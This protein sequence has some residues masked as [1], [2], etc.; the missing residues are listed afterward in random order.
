MDRF[1]PLFFNIS[2]VE[3]EY[4]DPQERLFLECV[5]GAMEDAGYTRASLAVSAA[6]PHSSGAAPVGVY[7]GVMCEE[8]QLFG[9][10]E[11]AKGRLIALSG[12]SG[13]IANR[14]SYFCNFEGPS[15]AV[16]TMCS[17]SMTAIHLAC[18][19]LLLGECKLAIA[20][21]V[22]V[23]IHP[24]KFVGLAR[25]KFLSTTGRCQAFGQGADGYVPGEGVGAVLLKP[26]ARAIADGD[27]IYGVI[28]GSAVNHGA[29]S[30]GYTV[31]NPTAQAN[32]IGRALAQA[33]IAPRA[34]GY[35]EAHGTGTSLGDPIEI[36]ALTRAI[37]AYTGDLHFCAIGSV[38]SNIGHCEGAAGIA[39]VT[40][41]LLQLKH[42]QLAPTLHTE[43]LNPNID[44][45]HSPFVVQQKLAAWQRSCIEVD[46]DVREYP[47]SAGVSSFGAGGSNA[48]LI[49]E[50]YIPE[51]RPPLYTRAGVGATTS[52][53][54]IVLSAKDEE[55]LRE[56]AQQLLA[57]VT[58]APAGELNLADVAYTLQVGREAMPQRLA[59]SA[60]SIEE[61]TQK[62]SAYLR[63]DRVDGLFLG[64][65][66]DRHVG[67]VPQRH[68]DMGDAFPGVDEATVDA[69]LA[70]GAFAELLA[71][72]VQGVAFDW[73]RLYGK[74]QALPQRLSLPTYPF[75][76]QRYW[77]PVADD[78]AASGGATSLVIDARHTNGDLAGLSSDG[79][80]LVP[81]LHP[82]LHRNTSTLAAVRFSTTFTGRETFLA[83][84]VVQ[85]RRVLPA[86]T[87][88]EMARA[89][90]TLAMGAVEEKHTL[91][92][93]RLR[94]VI[95]T[96]PIGLGA[97]ETGPI[98][99]HLGLS[100]ADD[101][102][103][104]YA[105]YQ[106]SGTDGSVVHSQGSVVACRFAQTLYLDLPALRAQ[107]S[108]A[109]LNAEQCYQAF[110]AIGIDY[111]P[112]HRAIETLYVGSSQVLAKLALPDSMVD[113]RLVLHPSLLDGALQ[114]TIGLSHNPDGTAS[115]G[116]TLPF[117]LDELEVHGACTATMWAFIRDPADGETGGGMRKLDIDICDETGAVHVR[118]KGFSFRVLP[119]LLPLPPAQRRSEGPQTPVDAP[120]PAPLSAGEAK[121]CSHALMLEPH[122]QERDI[123]EDAVAP[124]YTQHLAILCDLGVER[125]AAENG[126]D[127]EPT[128][129]VGTRTDGMRY[130]YLDATDEGIEQRFHTYAVRVFEEIR[131]ILEG[132]PRGK[133]LV[134]L[135]VP[136]QG[137]GRLC[138][139]LAGLLKTASLEN[140]NLISQVIEVD[141][142]TAGLRK[143]LQANARCPM[144]Q[145]ICYRDGKRLVASWREVETDLAPGRERRIPWRD[146][147]VYLITGGAGG[148]GL[149]FAEEIVQRVRDVT[150][151]LAG[152]SEPDE[153][154]RVL[155]EMLTAM[156]SL[157]THVEYRRLDVGQSDAV[158][159]LVRDM[160]DT[161][162]GLHGVLHSAGVTRDNFILE[163]DPQ[164]LAAV[165]APKVAGCVH[166]DR[167]CQDLD[168][169]VLFSSLTGVAGNPGQ[170][171]Y[172]AANAFMDAFAHY[173]N[174]LVCDN[175]RRGRTLSID[176]PLWREGGMRV[177]PGME[178]LMEDRT[179]L[180]PMATATGLA[181]FYQGLAL[182]ADQ[183]M[184]L[185]GDTVQLRRSLGLA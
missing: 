147:G 7:V 173:R 56:R 86:V 77:V 111:G 4:M 82:L 112:A 47:R 122:W 63:G 101:G 146:G 169:F 72:W 103:L 40:K 39:G 54:L 175:Q 178:K 106:E 84:H 91:Q 52:P 13:S 165:L 5:Y 134:Q 110:R 10:E 55:R 46:G 113:S 6:S 3:A 136:N 123:G 75:A 144:D 27:H 20:G 38:K 53:A 114:A 33:G 26:L 98:E 181:A 71:A 59:L 104:D 161:F 171:D 9:V 29:K 177:D 117:A 23:S 12:M 61:L 36:S 140:P 102:R 159:R 44:F 118:M 80:P 1:D 17:S 24:N 168:F 15:L 32:V 180:V 139:G 66:A 11:Q 99:V 167:A 42:R 129:A 21:G 81:V 51:A 49:I 16:N 133:V 163:K 70:R 89:A 126:A 185:E 37:G 41:V 143:I 148:L 127:E 85:G 35:L 8:Y 97:G 14:V 108:L 176:W 94:H 179:G 152:R 151:V 170:A 34:I 166:L 160:T 43:P 62:L 172:A 60:T 150:V 95:W 109:T 30:N 162:G 87:Y 164:E 68:R 78:E 184:V 128:A 48:H 183:V 83:D 57:F 174:A 157:R 107:C 149:I 130:L 22:S 116:L 142:H 153:R 96:Q 145:Q 120:H 45:E 19:S 88:L 65:A 79:V 18:Q 2:P 154:T 93:I 92:G 64:R 124:A 125:R 28:K 141:M 135:A 69:W 137:E 50:E 158:E 156:G 76:R 182:D 67:E 119:S 115:S 74:G 131:R 121:E 58:D 132:K 155:M 105:I 100:A 90:A 25:G 138:V 31:P 73:Y